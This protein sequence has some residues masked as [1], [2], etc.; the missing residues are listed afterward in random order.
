MYS[1]YL[2]SNEKIKEERRRSSSSSSNSSIGSRGTKKG[3]FL[4]VDTSPLENLKPP[5]QFSK[6]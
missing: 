1:I 4:Q 2:F 5:K 3:P 6:T